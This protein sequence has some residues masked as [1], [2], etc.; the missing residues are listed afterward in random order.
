[1]DKI[2][3]LQN[4][5]VNSEYVLDGSI[6]EI[7]NEGDASAKR[8]ISLKIII[9]N[10]KG[11]FKLSTWEYK[12]LPIFNISMHVVFKFISTTSFSN[13]FFFFKNI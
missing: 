12:M 10:G 11:I 6:A 5:V 4:L 1:M 3:S 7:I 8:P 2:T 13:I 9:E